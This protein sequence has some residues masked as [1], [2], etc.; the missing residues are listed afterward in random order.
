MTKPTIQ[1]GS[2]STN[3]SKSLL[4]R[5]AGD[6]Y[7]V[8]FN[9]R[10]LLLSLGLF[11]LLV[12]VMIAGLAL[13]TTVLNSH[14]VFDALLGQASKGQ[15][16]LVN[17]FR[18]PRI[19]AGLLAG[20]ALA[21]AGCLIQNVV[22]NRLA[23]PDVLGINEGA[24]LLMLIVLI[25]S[26]V[27]L[28][29]PWWVAPVGALVSGVLLLIIAGGLGTRGYRV[30]LVGLAITYLVRSFSE[31]MLTQINLQHATATFSWTIGNLNGRGYEV[32]S[33][34]AF[35]LLILTPLSLLLSRQLQLFK[36]GEDIACTLGVKVR[37]TQLFAICLA[38]LLAGLA[39]GIGGPIG[40]VA[41]AAPVIINKLL[42][43]AQLSI[44]NTGLLGGILVIVADTLGR[45]LVAPIE[46]PVGVLTNILG[47]P[48]LLWVLLTEKNAS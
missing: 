26:N 11:S 38:I 35:A 16:L 28:M 7:S 33:P 12:V 13:G 18:L 29:G 9:Q 43:D 17:E 48:F 39:V 19:M 3:A 47:G 46:I 31:L 10:A 6:A 32:A 1:Y 2:I 30:I 5:L 8:V 44:I 42:G 36:L 40:F 25:S 41:I 20:F 23:T 34:V 27:G 4:I 21:I 45:V 15:Q 24:A 37:R 22:K 14:T